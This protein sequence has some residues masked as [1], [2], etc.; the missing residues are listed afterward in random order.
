[1]PFGIKLREVLEMAGAEDAAAVQVGGPPARWS[2][3]R[4]SHDLLRR[5]GHRRL[6]HGLPR[7]RPAG[8]RALVHGL[9]RRGELRLLHALPGRQ[10]LLLNK[11]LERIAGQGR[12]ADLTYLEELGMT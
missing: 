8:D 12:A 6:D 3:R 10:R 5:S 7:A 4:T 11:R 2:A 1:V 9:L